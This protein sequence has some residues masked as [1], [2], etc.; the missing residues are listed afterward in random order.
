M[1][2]VA[3]L[4]CGPSGL[5]AAHAS[6]INQADFTIF[7]RKR[8]SPLFGAQYLHEPITGITG[9]GTTVR[10]E[11]IG[12]DAEDYRQKVYGFFNGEVS[13]E[14]LEREHQAWDIRAAYQELWRRYESQIV[15]FDIKS[16]SQ[17]VREAKLERF[18]VVISTIPRTTWATP[19]CSFDKETIY[20][21]GDAPELGQTVPFTLQ[22]DNMILLDAS[23]DVSW[24]RL[25]KVFGY[26]TIEWPGRRKPPVEGVQQ[27]FKPLSCIAHGATDFLHMGRYGEWKKG[28]LTTDVFHQALKVTA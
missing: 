23:Q 26:S 8:Q 1:R 28:V 25:S 15:D 4:G 9:A 14:K 11:L 17:V 20:A 12:G 19:E 6:Q 16:H 27:W 18:D 13:P 3:I 2:K 10:Y 21:I 24:Y 7:S 22:D 5:L